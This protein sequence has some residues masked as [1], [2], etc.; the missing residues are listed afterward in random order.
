MTRSFSVQDNWHIEVSSDSNIKVQAETTDGKSAITGEIRYFGMR[1]D[2]VPSWIP[3]D[4]D[5]FQTEGLFLQQF[6]DQSLHLDAYLNAPDSDKSPEALSYLKDD[7]IL[8]AI[9]TYNKNFDG[10]GRLAAGKAMVFDL[11]GIADK[12]MDQIQVPENFYSFD[13]ALAANE[14]AYR[15]ALK[16]ELDAIGDN[17]DRLKGRH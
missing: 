16:K 1:L 9:D 7:R 2:N 12:N 13:Q 17:L 14:L 5:R 11:Q 15:K 3:I 10:D 4:W 8:K 6:H